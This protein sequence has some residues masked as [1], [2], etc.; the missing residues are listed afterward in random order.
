MKTWSKIV[1]GFA[2]VGAI[3]A[4]LV[5]FFVYNKAHPDYE[6]MKPDFIVTAS[7][8]YIFCKDP[9]QPDP[10]KFNGKVLEVSGI[11]TKVESTDSLVIAVF[12][13]DQGMFGDQGVRC[14]VKTKFREAAMK[15]Q[16]G[17]ICRIKGYCAGFNDSDVILEQCSI[18]N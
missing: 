18:I 12:V 10:A 4:V 5:Y 15:L 14:T 6:T 13:L 2:A 3:A 8:L 17:S 7:E 16:P 11:L 9:G 1:L